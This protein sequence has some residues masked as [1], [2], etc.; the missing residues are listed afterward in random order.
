MTELVGDHTL[1]AHG[2]E[3]APV[4][5]DIGAVDKNLV[6]YFP[7]LGPGRAGVPAPGVGTVPG[8]R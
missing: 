3:H 6:M 5:A 7:G 1:V 8:G 4:V 2:G